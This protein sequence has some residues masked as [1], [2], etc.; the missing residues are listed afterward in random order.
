MTETRADDSRERERSAVAKP[1]ELSV[2]NQRQARKDVWEALNKA[3]NTLMVGHAVGLV[4]CL[5]L[6]KDYKDN[7]QLEGV[8]I[9]IM[10]FG[11]GLIIAAFSV[12]AWIFGAVNRVFLP[13]SI[14]ENPFNI[15]HRQLFWTTAACALLSTFLMAAAILIAVFKFGTL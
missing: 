6:I 12:L 4:T 14:R 5:T 3:L 9:F 1:Q 13:K 15:P 8:G 10:L 2:E 11:Y 7:P